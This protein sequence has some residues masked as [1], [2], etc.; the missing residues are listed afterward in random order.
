MPKATP[1]PEEKPERKKRSRNLSRLE[2]NLVVRGAQITIWH[3]PFVTSLFDAL[4]HVAQVLAPAA[5]STR[6]G[7]LPKL[8]VA[9]KITCKRETKL[10][11]LHSKIASAASTLESKQGN[12]VAPAGSQV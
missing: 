10:P 9:S 11:I 5:S 2:T 3:R 8:R 4:N 1:K 6:D 7:L 12:F